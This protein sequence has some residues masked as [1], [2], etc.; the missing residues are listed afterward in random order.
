MRCCE[1]ADATGAARHC[2]GGD[3]LT[4]STEL[5]HNFITALSRVSR[6][7]A[8]LTEDGG[9]AQRRSLT[10]E[11]HLFLGLREVHYGLHDATGLT[12][13]LR[14]CVQLLGFCKRARDEAAVR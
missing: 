8:H 4:F 10:N 14:N 6:R 7:V 3:V 13:C 1:S 11:R 12:N 2:K 5:S 9:T